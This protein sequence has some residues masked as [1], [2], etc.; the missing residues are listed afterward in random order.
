[1]GSTH[2][3]SESSRAPDRTGVGGS[4]CSAWLTASTMPSCSMGAHGA[5]GVTDCS[6]GAL[7][8]ARRHLEQS[9]ALYDAEQHQTATPSV[10]VE[11]TNVAEVLWLLGYPTQALCK[12]R[13]ALTMVQDQS[14]VFHVALTLS[15]A[16]V[17]Y[18][19]SPRGVDRT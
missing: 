7:P 18:V 9:I 6:F 15:F 12:T 8:T 19:L 10:M 16:L 13:E 17:P 1:M 3:Y 14:S 11:L 4:S 2:F 5:C